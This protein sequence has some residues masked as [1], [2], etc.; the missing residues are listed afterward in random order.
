MQEVSPRDEWR[1]AGHMRDFSVE[2]EERLLPGVCF[3]PTAINSLGIS[4]QEIIGVNQFAVGSL[5]SEFD[6]KN[7]FS[8][9]CLFFFFFLANLKLVT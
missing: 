3:S 1:F 5:G 4:T 2:L 8:L 6:P 9:S 7:M